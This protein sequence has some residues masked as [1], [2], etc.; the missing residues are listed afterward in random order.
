MISKERLK[1][2]I[3]SNK[4]FI[5][6]IDN[7]VERQ[8]IVLPRKLNKVVV[9][10]GPRRSG[11]SFVMYS[12]FKIDPDV[13]LYIDF[14][15][16][17]LYGFKVED[18]EVLKESFL[19][20][21]PKVIG[22]RKFFFFD[23]VQNVVGW[24][25][26]CRRLVEKENIYVYVAGSSSKMMIQEIHTSVRGRVWTVEITPFSFKE[27]LCTK[28][29]T[30]DEDF[31]YGGKKVF[32]KKYFLEF[33]KWGG[34]P[35]VIFAENEF[36][37]KKIL[38]DYLNSM[39]FRDLVERFKITNIQL[40]EVLIDKLFSSYS[41]KFSLTAFYKQYKDLFPFSKDKLFSYYKYILQSMFVLEVR[42]FAESSYKRLRNPAKIYLIDV[43]L[44]KR[45]TTENYGRL[46]ENIVFLALRK[47][48]EQI[49]YFEEDVE[50]DFVVEKDNKFLPYQVCY[51]LNNDNMEREIK[52]LITC[53]KRVN[54]KRG[55]IVTYD[56][57]EIRKIDNVE[58]E[59]IP[60]WKWLLKI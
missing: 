32:T 5:L 16:E 29:K 40:L 33:M 42:K 43:G 56:Q 10:Y 48:S 39:F 49:F 1:E 41:L 30:I 14:E 20:L 38:N 44:A 27:F 19:E 23:E 22:K 58:V 34:F 31:I 47:I 18:F 3:I 13:S 53:C 2:I 12:L 46:L 9:F 4:G 8:G 24:E 36:E 26:F 25:K 21:N 15:D 57:E 28:E 45:V 7:I 60:V 51:E 59:I 52:G 6:S 55:I 50:C 54:A 37:K 11:K 35:E 17:R